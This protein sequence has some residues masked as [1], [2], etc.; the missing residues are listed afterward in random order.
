MTHNNGTVSGFPRWSPD[1][2][3]IVFHLRSKSSASLCLLNPKTGQVSPMPMVSQNDYNPSY[4]Q[5][6]KWI[7]FSSRRTGSPEVWKI[8]SS[9]GVPIQLTRRGGPVPLESPN[10][11]F[12]YYVKAG[13]FDLWRQPSSS[14]DESRV[15]EGAIAAKGTAYAVSDSG[16]YLIRSDMEDGGLA[17]GFFDLTTQRFRPIS[18][19]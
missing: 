9:G 1:E 17:L 19:L 4:S 5:D 7:Y 18:R 3:S 14:G 15:F 6:G 11:R 12:V 10:G 8:S 16:V 13:P 2:G